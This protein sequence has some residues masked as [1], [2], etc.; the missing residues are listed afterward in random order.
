[1]PKGRKKKLAA[2][3]ARVQ[4]SAAASSSAVEEANPIKR[5]QDVPSWLGKAVVTEESKAKLRADIDAKA[6]LKAKYGDVPLYRGKYLLEADS[7]I[8]HEVM[9]N[10]RDQLSVPCSSTWG[11]SCDVCRFRQGP[12]NDR[13]YIC[14]SVW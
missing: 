1:M 10:F 4:T 13:S 12:S 8:N 14:W 2:R 7:I 5:D 6:A 9:H 11:S 3:A